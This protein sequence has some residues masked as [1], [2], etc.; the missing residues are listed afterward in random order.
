M[1]PLAPVSPVDI[2]EVTHFLRDVDLTLSGLDSASTRLWIKRDANGTIIASTGYELSDDGLHALILS[3][4]SGPFWQ[5][6]GFE[7]ADRYELAAALRTTR[8]VML[9]TETGQLDREVAWSRDLSH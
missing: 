6:L 7:P 5:K 4:R 3:R 1:Q 2:D 9:F 8:Q